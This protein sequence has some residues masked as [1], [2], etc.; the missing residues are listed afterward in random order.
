MTGYLPVGFEFASELT[1]PE[2]EVTASGLL[3]ASS[4]IFGI[5]LTMGTFEEYE[6][7]EKSLINA[8][9]LYKL[10][11]GYWQNTVT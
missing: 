2:P 7:Y 9:I 11:D 6:T 3:N 8:N 5:V 4:Q 10:V 1:Y